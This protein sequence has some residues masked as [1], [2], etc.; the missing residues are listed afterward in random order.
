MLKHLQDL[1]WAPVAWMLEVRRP[2][3]HRAVRRAGH[4]PAFADWVGFFALDADGETWFS[5]RPDRWTDAVRVQELK[6]RHV[7]RVQ[8]ARWSRK[9]KRFAPRRDAS[10]ATCPSCR[11]AGSTVPLRYRHKFLCEC[12]GAGWVPAG[13]GAGPEAHPWHRA[14]TSH[15]TK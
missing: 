14:G 6:L 3:W 13:W 10:A 4:F 2:S 15:T 5:E 7:A 1:I 12:G 11:G 9:M 8:A